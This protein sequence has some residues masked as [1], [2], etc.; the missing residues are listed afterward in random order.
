MAILENGFENVFLLGIRHNGDSPK[1]VDMKSV[2]ETLPGLIE[3]VAITENLDCTLFYE[4][5]RIAEE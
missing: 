3:M 1:N 5:D 4:F 2:A